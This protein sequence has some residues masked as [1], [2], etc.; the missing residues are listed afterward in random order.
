MTTKQYVL[1][2]PVK[3]AQSLAAA[4]EESGQPVRQL[5]IQCVR[6]ALP[7]VVAA[8]RPKSGR[9]TNVDPL[10]DEVLDRIYSQPERDEEGIERMM[11]AQAIGGRD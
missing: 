5:I 1:R 11:R 4:T 9:I 7:D 2:L 10:P 3:D 8:L 6:R